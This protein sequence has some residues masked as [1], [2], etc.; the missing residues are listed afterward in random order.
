MITLDNR[1]LLKINVRAE[2]QKSQVPEVK[3]NQASSDL[4]SKNEESE[5]V[6]PQNQSHNAEVTQA[7]MWLK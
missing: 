5:I 1:R 4:R 3:V 7:K 2:E 6:V